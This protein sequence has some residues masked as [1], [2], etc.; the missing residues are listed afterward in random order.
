MP[1][2]LVERPKSPYWIIP[3]PSGESALRKALALA[4]V[5][6]PRKSSSSGKPRSSNNQSTVVALPQHSRQQR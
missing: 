1:L 4:T 6:R 3:A 5:E 2:R